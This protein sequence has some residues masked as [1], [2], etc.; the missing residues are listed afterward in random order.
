MGR[1]RAVY[2]QRDGG[3]ELVLH[4]KALNLHKDLCDLIDNYPWQ[5][6]MELFEEHG[7]GGGFQFTLGDEDVYARYDFTPIDMDSVELDFYLVL[8]SGFLGF[9]GRKSLI[10]QY[11][12]ISVSEAKEKM[13]DLFDRP[14]E[15]LYEKHKK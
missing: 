4:E 14:I 9:I 8:K 1:V 11:G 3:I 5:S 7:V 12:I 13:K 6:E 2:E 15:S 10:K